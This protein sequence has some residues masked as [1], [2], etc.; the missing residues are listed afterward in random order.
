MELSDIFPGLSTVSVLINLTGALQVA[1]NAMSFYASHV[2]SEIDVFVKTCLTIYVIWYGL[3]LM[4]GEV[5]EVMTDAHIRVFKV[6]L[7]SMLALNFANYNQIVAQFAWNMP[8]D[9]VQWLIPSNI[10]TNIA[11]MA[12]S[13]DDATDLSIL[14]I[15]TVMSAT[16]SIMQSSLAA[17]SISGQTDPTMFAAGMGVGVAGAG[18]TAVVAGILLV[19]KMSLSVLLALG[20]LFIVS[21]LSEKTKAYFDGWL[22]QVLNF[23]LVILLL[24]LTIYI[25][26]PILI[27]TVSSYYLIA[28]ATGAL[29]LQ[30]SVE[31][32][33][34][35]GIFLAVIKQVP[36]TAAA[37]VRG[38]AVTPAQERSV[39]GGGGQAHDSGKSANQANAEQR[40]SGR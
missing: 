28:Q 10:L 14:L 9:L 29:S 15:S 8:E 2:V 12:M 23:V 24:T 36:T 17:S 30:E 11:N 20:P 31:L 33:T 19:A 16:V 1:Q 32:I 13:S 5:K 7:V 25:L 3:A 40:A 18:I 22:S 39:Q 35:L 34:L 37:V 21:I 6:A 38:Y 27:I 26:F 4:R